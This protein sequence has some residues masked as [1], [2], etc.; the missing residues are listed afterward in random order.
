MA[1]YVKFWFRAS[2]S[3]PCMVYVSAYGTNSMK[4]RKFYWERQRMSHMQLLARL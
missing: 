1:F 2:M 3:R 4:L